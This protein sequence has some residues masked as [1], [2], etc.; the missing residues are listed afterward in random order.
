MAS[1]LPA[2]PRLSEPVAF[3]TFGEDLTTAQDDVAA[4]AARD[5]QEL[6]DPPRKRADRSRG[7]DIRFG[8]VEKPSLHHGYGPMLSHARTAITALIKIRITP[9]RHQ[10]GAVEHLPRGAESDASKAPDI[11]QTASTVVYVELNDTRAT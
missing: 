9:M 10:T 11:P 5:H 8:H 1:A 2:A 4:E 3:E 7:A 6:Y